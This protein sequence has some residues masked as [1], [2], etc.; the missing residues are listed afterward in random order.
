MKMCWKIHCI[1]IKIVPPS[2]M[3]KSPAT[4]VLLSLVLIGVAAFLVAKYVPLME[5]FGAQGGEM[6]QLAAG[7]VP[8]EED[9]E[10][11]QE[12]AQQRRREI[13]N[14]TGYW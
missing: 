2:R 4:A 13:V 10:E 3:R 11:L 6:V 8:T 1:S 9:V 14:M 5:M 12:E 7:H